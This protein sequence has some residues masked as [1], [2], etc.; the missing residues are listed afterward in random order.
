MSATPP[1]AITPDDSMRVAQLG[2]ATLA[3]RPS[4][5]WKGV[6][7]A[8][9]G[10]HITGL[11]PIALALS[12]AGTSHRPPLAEVYERGSDLVASFISTAPLTVRPEIYWRMSTDPE[13]QAGGV[14]L[15]LSIETWLLASDP[16]CNLLS[17]LPIGEVLTSGPDGEFRGLNPAT[18][19]LIPERTAG[20]L[21]RPELHAGV[22]YLQLA[23]PADVAKA[24]L[25][26][27]DPSTTE[28]L[29]GAH[30][31]LDLFAESLEKGVIRRGRVQA[32]LIPRENDTLTA[33]RL[34]KAFLDSPPPLT[35]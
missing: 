33:A 29:I 8:W 12:S 24:H 4:H 28:L 23:Q 2:R 5:P 32:W 14:E 22:S 6:L 35:T 3:I 9:D 31:S 19:A 20:L 26:R 27:I 10:E 13:T 30:F 1:A 21:C 18:T 15:M 16:R 25:T 17:D 11:S 7:L 34:L